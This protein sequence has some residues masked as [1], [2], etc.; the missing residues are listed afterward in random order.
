MVE[1]EV[2]QIE[3]EDAHQDQL[4]SGEEAADVDMADQ[5]ESGHL[6]SSDLHME[7]NTEDNPPSA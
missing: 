2:C 6:D 5:E 7:A 1:E 4:N 3:K